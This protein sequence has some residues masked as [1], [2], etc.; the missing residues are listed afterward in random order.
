MAL[1]PTHHSEK[2]SLY[3]Q[4]QPQ[5]RIWRRYRW[6]FPQKRTWPRASSP[7]SWWWHPPDLTV[8]KACY[9][10]QGH[11]IPGP[12][13]SLDSSTTFSLPVPCYAT[14]DT[15][16][17][18]NSGTFQNQ[19][20]PTPLSFLWMAWLHLG[21]PWFRGVPPS[22]EETLSTL[23][24]LPCF[25]PYPFFWPSSLWL[26]LLSCLVFL[27]EIEHKLFGSAWVRHR[28]HLG[29]IPMQPHF[30]R[31]LSFSYGG[32]HLMNN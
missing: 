3:H 29:I 9:Q 8:Q 32:R 2:V 31:S 13:L 20:F 17:S 23:N 1:K 10:W 11:P 30:P 27:A 6:Y 21:Q 14:P 12:C 26:A 16:G 4:W 7:W 24:I 25:D 22:A 19:Y 5:H 28:T 18:G 15:S